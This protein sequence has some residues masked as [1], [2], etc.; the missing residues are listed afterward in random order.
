MYIY[1]DNN[2]YTNHVSIKVII[3]VNA[4]SDPGSKPG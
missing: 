2:F 4:I 3:I 1:Y